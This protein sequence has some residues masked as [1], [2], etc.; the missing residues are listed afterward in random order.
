[1]SASE[2][3]IDEIETA[4]DPVETLLYTINS[5][6]YAGQTFFHVRHAHLQVL[7]V[8]D[9]TIQ[10]CVHTAQDHQNEIVGIVGHDAGAIRPYSAAIKVAPGT[11]A[12][13]LR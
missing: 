1:M 12:R 3:L 9:D 7:D 11:F 6:V 8:L 2:G 5:T 10:F 13:R 4:F